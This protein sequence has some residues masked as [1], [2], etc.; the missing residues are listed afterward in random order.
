VFGSVPSLKLLPF[1]VM[2]VQQCN[3]NIILFL[4]LSLIWAYWRSLEAKG[5][6]MQDIGLGEWIILKWNLHIYIRRTMP[7]LRWS[8]AYYSPRSV[9]VEF[10]VVNVALW[11]VFL[12]VLWLSL[13]ILFHHDSPQPCIIWVMNNRPVDGRSSDI[14]SH[15]IDMNNTTKTKPN[16][17]F[18]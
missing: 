15:P 8:V 17:C 3:M 10:V 1:S 7:W 18:V 12:R 4:T 2:C 16:S 14:S 5:A 9:H 11:Q 6:I 13:S